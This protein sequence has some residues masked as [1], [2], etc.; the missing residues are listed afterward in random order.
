MGQKKNTKSLKYNFKD[1]EGIMK[2]E[3]MT[4][5]DTFLSKVFDDE[6]KSIE[7]ATNKFL[8]RFKYCLS[9]CFKKTRVCQDNKKNKA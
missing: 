1:P 2:F 8:K 7:V 9:K 4:S 5:K 3:E 6:S